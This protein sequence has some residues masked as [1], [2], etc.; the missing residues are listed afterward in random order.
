M[1]LQARKSGKCREKISGNRTKLNEAM[2]SFHFEAKAPFTRRKPYF[3]LQRS[4]FLAVVI[5]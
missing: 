2:A 5:S 4:I 3:K 1:Q